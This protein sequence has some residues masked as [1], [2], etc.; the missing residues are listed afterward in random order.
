MPSV[1]ELWFW[2][3]GPK[4]EEAPGSEHFSGMRLR[5]KSMLRAFS[6]QKVDGT[7]NPKPDT[8]HSYLERPSMAEDFRGQASS[9]EM[10]P[11][12]F[13]VGACGVGFRMS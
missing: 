8:K 10:C 11:E 9:R 4:P 2:L 7:S 3:E 1:A 5:V 6:Y 13:G 12:C